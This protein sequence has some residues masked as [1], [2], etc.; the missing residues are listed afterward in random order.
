MI[1][2]TLPG[3]TLQQAMRPVRRAEINPQGSSIELARYSVRVRSR[4]DKLAAGTA[5]VLMVPDG[6][7]VSFDMTILASMDRVS[8]ETL[9]VILGDIVMNLRAQKETVSVVTASHE[10]F[11]EI[12]IVVKKV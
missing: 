4:A 1:A 3:R 11:G 6:L 8:Q 2:N 9:F 5:S 7:G 12:A 10:Q